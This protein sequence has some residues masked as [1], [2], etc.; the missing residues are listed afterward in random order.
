MLILMMCSKSTKLLS[1]EYLL[2][3]AEDNIRKNCLTLP[4]GDNALEK[5]REVLRLDGKNQLAK[6]GVHRLVKMYQCR[7]FM[8][9][10]A[11]YH[12]KFYRR[13]LVCGAKNEVR[14]S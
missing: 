14:V 3:L 8:D 1:I 2:S 10:I 11:Q 4:D 5:Y 13:S 7:R 12:D 6:D 9:K